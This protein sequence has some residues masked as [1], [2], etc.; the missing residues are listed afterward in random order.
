MCITPF[1]WSRR[2]FLHQIRNCVGKKCQA[3][4]T[5]FIVFQKFD[6]DVTS[7]WVFTMSNV[8]VIRKLRRHGRVAVL[9]RTYHCLNLSWILFW[10]FVYILKIVSDSW[11]FLV[12]KQLCWWNPTLTRMCVRSERKVSQSFTDHVPLQQFDRWAC[13]TKISYDKKAE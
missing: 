11:Q 9:F 10:F 3:V 6:G 8:Y 4:V 2:A 5:Y 1:L 12:L 7:Y 13:T